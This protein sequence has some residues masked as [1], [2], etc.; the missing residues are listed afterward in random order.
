M[1]VTGHLFQFNS[2][3]LVPIKEKGEIRGEYSFPSRLLRA[4]VSSIKP[5][6]FFLTWEIIPNIKIALVSFEML[7]EGNENLNFTWT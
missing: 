7:V 2:A 3:N 4:W 5:Y 1:A 6:E